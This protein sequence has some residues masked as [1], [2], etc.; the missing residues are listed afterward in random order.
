MSVRHLLVARGDGATWCGADDGDV[1]TIDEVTCEACV[2]AAF[3]EVCPA[4]HAL[5]RRMAEL[6][7]RRQRAAVWEV[8]SGLPAEVAR[9]MEELTCARCSW[10]APYST[11][12]VAGR[13]THVG[14]IG[15]ARPEVLADASSVVVDVDEER[16][17]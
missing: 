4:Y 7:S 11:V 1:A 15:V 13:R 16:R 2:F 5:A 9:R 3:D 10:P 14:C 12:F 17:R 6:C 8:T